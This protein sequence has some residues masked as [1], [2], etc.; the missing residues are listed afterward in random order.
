MRAMGSTRYSYLRAPKASFAWGA[1]TVGLVLWIGSDLALALGGQPHPGVLSGEPGE[2]ARLALGVVLV[3]LMFGTP[4]LMPHEVGPEGV[5]VRQGLA[6]RGAIPYGNIAGIQPTEK[7]PIGG[8]GMR[9]YPDTLFV[10]TWPDRLIS[11]R[12][13][14]PQRFWLFRV[15][16]LWKV[17]EVVINVDDPGQFLLEVRQRMPRDPRS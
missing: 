1:I 8:L 15:V 4:F 6:F 3:L 12:L 7:K 9:P 13:R 5:V 16:P 17:S 10:V 2:A 14:R 11:I